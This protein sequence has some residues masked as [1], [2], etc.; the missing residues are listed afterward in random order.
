MLN[1]DIYW[2]EQAIV[3]NN[4]VMSSRLANVYKSL[5]FLN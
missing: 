3:I 4:D 1:S 5:M 2:I